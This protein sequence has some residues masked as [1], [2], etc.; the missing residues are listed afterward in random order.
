MPV[1]IR[2]R[3]LGVELNGVFTSSNTDPIPGGLLWPEAAL[4][5]NAMRAAYVADGGKAS[6]FEPAGPSSSARSRPAQDFFW[7]HQPPPAARPY[8]SNH[9]WAIAVDVKTRAAAAWI[10]RHGEAYGWSHDEGARVGEWWHYRYVGASKATLKRLRADAD[11]LAHYTAS[12]LRW[13][14][15]YDRLK[16]AKRDPDRRRVLQRVMTAQRKLIWHTAQ[17][18]S[19]GGDGHGWDY[20]N[21]RRRYAS[22]LARTK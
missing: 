16:R 10:M 4:T 15:E 14:R 1:A 17:P 3:Q 12:E 5:W 21:R 8:T 11:R 18:K 6:D 9:G 20:R 7:T 22:L 19:H 2:G 13:I